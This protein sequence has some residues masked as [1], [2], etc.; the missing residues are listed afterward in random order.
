M[1]TID[2]KGRKVLITGGTSG[3]GFSIA[4]ELLAGGAS[5]AVTGRSTDRGL[6]AQDQLRKAASNAHFVLGDASTWSGAESSVTQAARI[7]GGIDTLV[8]AGAEG[9]V[10]PMLFMDMA[11][12]QLEASF[13]SRV[14][15]RVFPVR[16]AVP[17]MRESAA[18]AIVL[19]TTDAGRHA[20]PGESIVG[21]TGASVILLT[22]ALA[23]EFSRW[24]IPV[25]AI[26]LTLTS[27]TPSYERIFSN[28]TF[29]NHLFSKALR[30][31]PAGRAPTSTEVSHA[32]VFLASDLASQ[33][34]G[35]TISVNGGLSFGGW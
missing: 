30:R 23:R 33:I 13:T 25:N 32:A 17:F 6:A 2:F 20:T 34:T 15:G 18:G 35:Q 22:K 26:A 31:F 7:L 28:P 3:I 19:V 10:S 9:A 11:P 4:Q 21:A 24:A 12:E 1:S 14:L 29:E 16:A 8:C 5:I 27:D